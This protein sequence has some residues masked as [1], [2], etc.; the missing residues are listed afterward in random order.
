MNLPL[1]PAMLLS[2]VNTN[3]RDKYASLDEFAA[4]EDADLDYITK[5]LALIDYTYD[6][7]RNQFV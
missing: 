3:L 4:A 6:P 5:R 1:D 7:I 2:V